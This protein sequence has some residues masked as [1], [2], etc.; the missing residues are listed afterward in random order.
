MIIKFHGYLYPTKVRTVILIN[1]TAVYCCH[2]LVLSWLT[3][4]SFIFGFHGNDK[5]TN[6]TTNTALLNLII[7]WL[8]NTYSSC[9]DIHLKVVRKWKMFYWWQL[10][11]ILYQL[12]DRKCWEN[13]DLTN[14][15]WSCIED[16]N[17]Y[18]KLWTNAAGHSNTILWNPLNIQPFKA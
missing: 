14:N 2:L 16:C 6:V 15:L 3:E 17:V 5:L 8:L 13:G 4:I 9:S 12:G 7:Y 18:I 10:W 1:D 11:L